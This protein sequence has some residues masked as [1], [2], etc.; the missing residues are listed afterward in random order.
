MIVFDLQCLDG[1]EL[2][3]AWFGSN[4]DFDAAGG[5]GPGA[6]SRMPIVPRR[7]GADGAAGASEGRE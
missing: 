6:L 3:E 5:T 2:F 4:A 1:G 7:E